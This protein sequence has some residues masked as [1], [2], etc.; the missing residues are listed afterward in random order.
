VATMTSAKDKYSR[1][2]G[3]GS[4]AVAKYNGAKGR[5]K[6]NWRA[7]MNGFLGQ[8]VSG[9]V[10]AAYDAGVDAADYRGGDPDKWQRNY[11]AAMT[12]G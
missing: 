10:A 12:G 3:P 1:K 11:L 6:T 7:G 4:P 5:M 2:T 8:P 9:A